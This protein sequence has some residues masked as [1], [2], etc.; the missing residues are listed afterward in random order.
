MKELRRTPKHHVWL[1]GLGLAALVWVQWLGAVH[2]VAHAPGLPSAAS[3]RGLAS[4]AA[5][6]EAFTPSASTPSDLIAALFA[7]HDRDHDCQFFDQLAHADLA[8][9]PTVVLPTAL[10]ALLH[11]SDEPASWLAARLRAFRARD[12]PLTLA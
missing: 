5:P 7:G 2:A 3:L 9:L 11:H 12:P 8:T 1:I 4:N 6:T 10:P